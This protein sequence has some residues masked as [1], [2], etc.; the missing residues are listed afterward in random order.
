[1]EISS[2]FTVLNATTSGVP[3][4][5]LDSPKRLKRVRF[6]SEVTFIDPVQLPSSPNSMSGSESPLLCLETLL[7]DRHSD[8]LFSS[9]TESDDDVVSSKA[10]LTGRKAKKTFQVKFGGLH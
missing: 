9:G 2:E 1:M 5:Q 10:I 3:P 6:A 7:E 4:K 8:S